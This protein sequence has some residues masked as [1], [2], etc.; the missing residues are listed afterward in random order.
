MVSGPLVQTQDLTTDT[1]AKSPK[2]AAGGVKSAPRTLSKDSEATADTMRRKS[3]SSRCQLR[4]RHQDQG[5]K[6]I[7]RLM[8]PPFPSFTH[9]SSGRRSIENGEIAMQFY[10]ASGDFGKKQTDPTAYRTGCRLIDVFA[11]ARASRYFSAASAIVA[12]TNSAPMAFR[13]FA[14]SYNGRPLRS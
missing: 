4:Q 14:S 9:A 5:R 11:A 3:G 1:A 10:A 7:L 13:W 2:R 6:R 8:I 12:V